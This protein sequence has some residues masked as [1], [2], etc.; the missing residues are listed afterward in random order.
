MINILIVDD[1]EESRYLLEALLKGN[2]YA[3]EPFA[4]GAEALERLRLGGIDLIVSDILMPVMDG[5]ALC[6]KV[7]TD[8]AL[9]Q[10]PL[11]FYTATYTGPQD[12]AFALKIGA[13]RFL[14]KPCEPDVLMEAVRS[15]LEGSGD[16]VACPA[17]E[18]L[19][20]KDVFKL[21]NERLVRKLEE[22]MLQ[23][24]K[25]S[26]SLREADQSLRSSEKKYRRLHESMTDGFVYVDM[27]GFVRESNEAYRK[28][29]GY[30]E[31]EL[32]RLTYQAL[33][34]EKWH[35]L[36]EDIVQGQVLQKG[37]S[38]V[39]EK[40]YRKKDGTVFPVEL[41]TFLIC[42]DSGEK[43]GMWAIVRDISERKRAEKMQ[44]ELEEQLHQAQKMESVGRLAGGV[45][46]DFN[47]MLAVI[48]IAIELI[49]MKL[50]DADPLC[51]HLMEIDRAATRARDITRQLLAFSRKQI[52]ERKIVALN[53]LIA[54]SV[55]AIIRLIGE[56][57][58][59]HFIPGQGIQSV[60]VDPSQVDQ[61][62]L[63]L[64]LNA[65]D[66]M[67]DGGTLTIE[68]AHA[69]Y[70]EAYCREHIDFKPGRYV[71]VSVSD[72]GHGID[73]ETL[74]KIFEPFFTTK[75]PWK[76]TG[77]GLA[78]VYGVMKQNGGFVKAYSEVGSGTTFKLYFPCAE[79]DEQG[80]G[81][82]ET[83][84]PMR[85]SGAILLVEDD[86]MLRRIIRT[87]LETIGYSVTAA[88][89]PA[90]AIS[91]AEKG[92]AAHV[93][94]LTDIVMPG[95]N[96]MQ[97]SERLRAVQPAMKVLFMSGY[98]ENVIVHRGELEAG[99]HFIQKPFLIQDLTR[100][101]REILNQ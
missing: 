9:R 21:Y 39:Y 64:A 97:L 55:K 69:A 101:I 77:L 96:G 53:K 56:D 38:D 22:K 93:L 61:V 14:V 35:A 74:G 46:H 12:E 68:T 81:Q 20:D 15:V 13:D 85:G 58:E 72:D 18:L 42:D 54:E 70:D 36:E 73:Q 62:L 76:G 95:M 71:S 47:N 6:H 75:E 7:K 78:M 25:E 24:E 43:E 98:A 31:E 29:L 32:S 89:T 84:E 33:T 49:R 67:P 1:Q 60:L 94:L 82:A 11:V 48:F 52:I 90:E 30:A 37:C 65:R 88:A 19:E 34:P 16:R 23:L 5:F 45:A 86:A 83:A 51:E 2:G 63:N 59:V 57:I 92:G 100:K 79:G 3:V 91:A 87:T 4:N 44:K 17:Q 28:M 26:T 80:V 41:R 27:Q 10:I 50:S 8:E 99:R 40:E 66:A